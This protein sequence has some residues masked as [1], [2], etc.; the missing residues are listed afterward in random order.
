MQNKLITLNL[1]LLQTTEV[2]NLPL[3]LINLNEHGKIMERPF[4]KLTER[5]AMWQHFAIRSFRPFRIHE[6]KLNF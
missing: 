6:I 5:L 1:T 3:H 4:I 2:F